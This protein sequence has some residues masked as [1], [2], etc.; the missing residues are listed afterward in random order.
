MAVTHIQLGTTLA[1][2]RVR[3]L[4]IN[5]EGVVSSVQDEVLTMQ[6]MITGDASDPV[7]FDNV[8]TN[9]GIVGIAP[10]TSNQGAKALWD[11]LNSLNGKINSDAAVSAVH[12]AIVQAANKVR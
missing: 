8:V 6:T 7:Q 9:Y 12:T 2:N 4:L 5:L 1:A 10:A 3:S 11:E